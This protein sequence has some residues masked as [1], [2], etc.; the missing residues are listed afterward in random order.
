MR[1]GWQVALTHAAPSLVMITSVATC[2]AAKMPA[3]SVNR[4]ISSSIASGFGRGFFISTR[5]VMFAGSGST[6]G[7]DGHHSDNDV[8]RYDPT[9]QGEVRIDRAGVDRAASRRLA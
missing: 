1:H 7:D 8:A 9:V 6:Q 3:A 4:F 5:T 2:A